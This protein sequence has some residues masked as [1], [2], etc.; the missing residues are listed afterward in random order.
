MYRV[1]ELNPI[2]NEW[3][4]RGWSEGKSQQAAIKKYNPQAEGQF[5][6]V[7]ES[8]FHPVVVGKQ[9]IVRWTYTAADGSQ[10]EGVA[11]DAE[12][13]VEVDG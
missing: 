2:T 10:A 6:A 3:I 7:P 8:S 11:E 13:P 1:F 4:D 5:F 9:E 12:T